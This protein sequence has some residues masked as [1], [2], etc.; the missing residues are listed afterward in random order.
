MASKSIISAQQI[1]RCTERLRFSV[2]LP[3]CDLHD[4]SKGI[5]VEE[6]V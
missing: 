5:I 2:M 1:I 6:E 3:T 4:E